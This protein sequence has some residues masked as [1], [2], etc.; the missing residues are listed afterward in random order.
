M[1]D[2]LEDQDLIDE[3][4]GKPVLLPFNIQD[5]MRARHAMAVRAEKD[6][7][8]QS[9]LIHLCRKSITFWLT[10]FVWTYRQ[11]QVTEGGKTEQLAGRASKQPLILRPKQIEVVKAIQEAIRDGHNLLIDKSREEGGSLLPAMVFMHEW[12]FGENTN[13]L[14]L[15]NKEENVDSRDPR[16]LFWKQ[17]FALENQPSWLKP[18][19]EKT[20]KHLRNLDADTIISGEATGKSSGL[21]ARGRA[22]LM[23][24]FAECANGYTI[25]ANMPSVS[26]CCIYVSTPRGPGTCFT[27]LRNEA[28][29]TGEPKRVELPW[30]ENPE[31][32]QDLEWIRDEKGR[33][34]R[35]SP[36]Y[37]AECLRM[38]DP[39]WIARNLNMSHEESGS[40]FF[41]MMDIQRQIDTYARPSI[42]DI[43]QGKI[44]FP[45]ADNIVAEINKGI[46]SKDVRGLEFIETDEGFWRLWCAIGEDGRPNQFTRYALAADISTGNGSSN[47]VISVGDCDTGRK[48]AEFAYSLARPYEA[49][50]LM[51]AAALWFGGAD[52][53][54]LLVWEAN[55]PGGEFGDEIWNSSYPRIWFLK[56][57]GKSDNER[58]SLYGWHSN[59]NRKEKVAGSF[60]KALTTDEFI[61]P[62]TEA[63][64]EA[65]EY[66]FFDG[67][68]LGPARLKDEPEQGRALHGDRVIADM[69]LHMAMKEEPKFSE[70]SRAVEPGTYAW[71]QAQAKAKTARKR[72]ENDLWGRE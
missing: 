15:S 71:L 8:Y 34:V 6:R 10:M 37:K 62:S 2:H 53:L 64:Q 45:H 40:M 58:T 65:A 24:E 57:S 61:N 18:H 29:R 17:M 30:W 48:V 44:I 4:T 68:A 21:A 46:R 43:K 72:S 49:A 51:L 55:G 54:P 32:A 20:F 33:V 28:L 60:R 41:D 36:W 22:V 59:R 19:Y 26:R 7:A 12:Q 42:P 47:T 69:L 9:T 35:T 13:F 56:D 63:L 16:S 39:I 70:N 66:V 3:R 25:H 14:M 5:N 38:K 23:D 67:G 50:R 52:A 27:W 11:M 1:P 31:K